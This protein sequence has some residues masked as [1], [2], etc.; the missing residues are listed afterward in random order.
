MHEYKAVLRFLA[1]STGLYIAWFLLYE[2]WLHPL[3]V[4]DLA[5]IKNAM[6]ISKYLLS[7]LGYNISLVSSR[8]IIIENVGGLFIGDPC[9]GLNL[10]A[11]FSG[12]IMAYP[13]P[14]ISK[15]IFIPIGI[16]GIHLLNVIRLTS[17]LLLTLKAPAYMEF[18][19]TFTFTILVYFFIFLLWMFWVNHY[20]AS[21]K[22]GSKI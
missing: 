8:Q 16:L 13:G 20:G 10:F 5:V 9:N 18:N 12:F 19:H 22:G 4:V 6:S 3:G 1:Y 15:L 21:R 14:I 7:S 11:L 2:L 17:L